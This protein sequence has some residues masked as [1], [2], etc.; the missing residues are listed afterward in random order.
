[1]T[2]ATTTQTTGTAGVAPA[3]ADLPPGV[4]ESGLAN[5]SSLVA[6]HEDSLAETGYEFEFHANSRY[7]NET[8]VG[9]QTGTVAAGLSTFLVRT[10]VEDDSSTY[11]TTTWA[12]E[13]VALTAFTSDGDRR[14]QE[15]ERTADTQKEITSQATKAT[16]LQSIL[17]SGEFSVA[18]VERAGDRTLTT[19]RADTYSGEGHFDGVSQYDATVVVD[20]SGRVHEFHWTIETADLRRES[21]FE[22]TAIGPVSVERPDWAGAAAETVNADLDVTTDEEF[23]VVHH[24]GGDALP[25]GSTID[26]GHDGETHTLELES[27]L[28]AGDDRYVHYPADGGDPVMTDDRPTDVD[29]ERIDGSYSVTVTD[30][31]GHAVLSMGFGVGHGEASAPSTTASGSADG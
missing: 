24:R 25:A 14:Y 13:S 9:T 17:E 18:S 10:S 21:D 8:S 20:S 12:N 28:D 3:T 30:P 23:V 27:P 22:L 6:A 7:A 29:A 19:L 2:D 4:T 11:Q 26:V 1:M 15:R 16:T 31:Q 5:A